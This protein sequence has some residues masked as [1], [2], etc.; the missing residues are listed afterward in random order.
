M[1]SNLSYQISQS[2]ESEEKALREEKERA[3]SVLRRDLSGQQVS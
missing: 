2:K 3:V 1:I